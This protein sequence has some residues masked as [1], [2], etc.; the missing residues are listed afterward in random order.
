[1]IILQHNNR[2]S[3]TWDSCYIKPILSYM[4]SPSLMEQ[5]NDIGHHELVLYQQIIT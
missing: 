1:M 5:P 4:Y 2:T 3:D